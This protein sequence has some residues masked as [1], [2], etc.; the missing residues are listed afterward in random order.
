MFYN[1]RTRVELQPLETSLA[2]ARSELGKLALEVSSKQKELEDV[3]SKL[4]SST[5]SV[6]LGTTPTPVLVV[7]AISLIINFMVGLGLA[8]HLGTVEER[9]EIA[10]YGKDWVKK[11]L[12]LSAKRVK[13]KKTEKPVTKEIPETKDEK[14]NENSP[15]WTWSSD[16]FDKFL[17][18]EFNLDWSPPKVNLQ[19][20]D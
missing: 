12:A 4:T 13:R 7:L 3:Q 2:D 5:S 10:L 18:S 16:F 8:S 6:S 11:V 9:E 20:S 15:D 1:L 17:S 14:I 19:S